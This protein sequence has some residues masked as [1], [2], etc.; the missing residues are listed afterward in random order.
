[1]GDW[2]NKN[3]EFERP[4]S[5]K[6]KSSKVEISPK[7]LMSA[8]EFIKFAQHNEGIKWIKPP[9]SSITKEIAGNDQWFFMFFPPRLWCQT[10]SHHDLIWIC[11]GFPWIPWMIIYIYIYLDEM[12]LVSP[13]T[14]PCSVL[15][16]EM[17]KTVSWKTQIW[18]SDAFRM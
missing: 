13:W 12:A 7:N 14:N 1:M 2:T 6:T 11:L 4:A 5:K 16:R 15:M 18:N 17:A 10:F 9:K 8:W 3:K